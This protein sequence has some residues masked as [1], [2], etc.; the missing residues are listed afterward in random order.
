MNKDFS[1]EDDSGLRTEN[2]IAIG[3]TPSPF[4]AYPVSVKGRVGTDYW[5]IFNKCL[6][7]YQ[8]VKWI[9]VV[10]RQGGKLD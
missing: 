4:S 2:E 7:N 10:K 8:P 1:D 6:S 9:S 5:K 3:F